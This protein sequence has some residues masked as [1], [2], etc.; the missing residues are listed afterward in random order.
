MRP[1]ISHMREI[2]AP[3]GWDVVEEKNENF[4][5]NTLEVYLVHERATSIMSTTIAQL[6]T[7]WLYDYKIVVTC[8]K[9]TIH[10]TNL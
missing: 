8:G 10:I 7:T 4:P 3:M 6:L 2:F 9:K 1:Q 5:Y